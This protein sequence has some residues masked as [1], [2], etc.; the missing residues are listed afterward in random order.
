[1]KKLRNLF[2]AGLLMTSIGAQMM[3]PVMAKADTPQDNQTIEQD[4]PSKKLNDD[5]LTPEGNL[6]L[7][8]DVNKKGEEGKQFITM[9]T[10]NGNYFYLVIDRDSEGKNT[11][12][13][14]NQVDEADL[15]AL[16]EDDTK[17]VETDKKEEVEKEPVKE[18]KPVEIEKKPAVTKK[19]SDNSIWLLTGILVLVFGGIAGVF[20]F[21]EYK[22]RQDDMKHQ[23]DPDEYYDEDD[24]QSIDELEKDADELVENKE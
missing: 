20:G 10:K 9:V 2:L 11:V 7:V 14:L 15:L 22:K 21:K 19:Q 1:M 6:T 12:H 23:D 4:E 8:D 24:E 5:A 16:M 13:F 18:E 17:K 3:H